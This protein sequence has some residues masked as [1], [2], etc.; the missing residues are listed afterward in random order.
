[1]KV[2]K[3]VLMLGL[4]TRTVLFNIVAHRPLVLT[5][6][7]KSHFGYSV[8]IWQ[9]SSET[10]L[11]VGA[12]QDTGEKMAE[13]KQGGEDSKGYARI[14]SGEVYLCDPRE[15]HTLCSSHR[16]KLPPLYNHSNKGDVRLLGSGVYNFGLGSTLLTG[17]SNNPPLLMCAPRESY[18]MK[19]GNEGFLVPEGE[20]FLLR[21]NQTQPQ[22]LRPTSTN[23]QY[24]GFSAAFDKDDTVVYLGCPS[25]INGFQ[26]DITQPE[27]YV[28]K[29]DLDAPEYPHERH[30][31]QECGQESH[32]EGWAM[33]QRMLASSSVVVTSCGNQKRVVELEMMTQLLEGARD[34]GELLGS[35]LESCD[36]D[37]D[38]EDEV[39]VGAPLG[40]VHTSSG[41]T[42]PG[43][44]IILG[45][46]GTKHTMEGTEDFSRFGTS[47]ACLG[48]LNSDGY[49]D[50]AVGAPQHSGGGA[51]FI[52][53]GSVTG[54]RSS[55]SQVLQ[56]AEFS[57]SRR[58]GFGY[59]LAG[60]KDVDG[61]GYP[62]LLVGAP[63]S[64]RK[65]VV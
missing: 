61:N 3:L 56:L 32:Y 45:T 35:V 57:S 42:E 59:S 28:L 52:F 1:M 14:I 65:S 33:T 48:D 39:L 13:E 60:G 24:C 29:F 49:Q 51:V 25:I 2:F 58:R 22:R 46:K 8:A 9:S 63:M 41:Y 23:V 37:G 50:V 10:K 19:K 38:G 55:P 54:I 47:I 26:V 34:T 53:L 21:P 15:G 31:G 64:D 44:V 43:K 36:L 12:P 62:D 7:D 4:A 18:Y 27:G 20:C 30:L 40:K 5:G 6:N 16:T 17:S 11:V